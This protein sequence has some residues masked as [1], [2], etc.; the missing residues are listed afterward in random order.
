MERRFFLIIG[1]LAMLAPQPV[2]AKRNDEAFDVVVVGAGS[3]GL[4]AAI[5]AAEKGARV[6]VLEADSRAVGC[7]RGDRGVHG[8]NRLGG[9]AM[10]AL[11]TFGPIAGEEAAKRALG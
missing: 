8:G 6:V 10:T 1:S 2:F 5:V 11:F 4:S 9:N 7:G 3:A